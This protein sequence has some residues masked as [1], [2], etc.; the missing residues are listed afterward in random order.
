MS[1]LKNGKK[2]LSAK[3]VPTPVAFEDVFGNELAIDPGLKAEI[4]SQN[5]TY[6]WINYKQ[7]KAMGGYHRFGY[8]PYKPKDESGDAHTFKFGRSPEGYIQRDDLILAVRD[9]ELT[10][11]FKQ[12]IDSENQRLAM[13][14]TDKAHR[15]ELR[16]YNRSRG[17][18]GYVEAGYE[19]PGEDDVE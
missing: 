9:K 18:K 6:R 8:R 1:N 10:E 3:P 4:E 2:P 17:I 11:K 7:L 19:D 5:L 16:E 14:A 12:Y 15:E 13:G